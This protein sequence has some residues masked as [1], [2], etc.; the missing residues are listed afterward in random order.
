MSHSVN[1][2]NIDKFVNRVYTHLIIAIHPI[3][4]EYVPSFTNKVKQRVKTMLY[5]I[6]SINGNGTLPVDR[7]KCFKGINSNQVIIKVIK[8]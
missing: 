4:G 2:V 6:D 8:L 3:T 1:T 5:N 7:F